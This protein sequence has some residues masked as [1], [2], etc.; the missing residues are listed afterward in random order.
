MALPWLDLARYADAHGYH[1]DSHRDMSRW[2]DWVIDAL[3]RNMGYDQFV[4]EQLAGDMIP[5]A[6][7]EQKI[8]PDS[9]GITPSITK[10]APF[11]KN[12]QR[13]IF[14]IA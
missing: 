14:S 2:R 7:L 6:T 12:T 10:A 11:R 9:T 4:A 8:A 13:L 5:N 3:N 1:I